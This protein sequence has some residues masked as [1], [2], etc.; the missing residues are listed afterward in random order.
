MPKQ[1]LSDIDPS[2][3]QR[4]SKRLIGRV[5]LCLT[6]TALLLAGT[7]ACLALNLLP[8]KMPNH[9]QG[10]RA[11]LDWYVHHGQSQ[12]DKQTLASAVEFILGR[13]SITTEAPSLVSLPLAKNAEASQ[14]K[15]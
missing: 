6:G 10:L 8:P 4:A 7:V 5:T 3:T 1:D 2:S 13:E 12:A 15:S 14:P 11:R 9:P